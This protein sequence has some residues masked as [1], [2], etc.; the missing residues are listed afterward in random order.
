MD[1]DTAV[2]LRDSQHPAY[3]FYKR[4]RK[5]LI[6]EVFEKGSGLSA[7]AIFK[8]LWRGHRIEIEDAALDQI[9]TTE[10]ECMERN[11]I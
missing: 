4:P 8:V 3:W 2:E 11:K 5:I 7:S 1:Y 9:Y 10:L 6:Q